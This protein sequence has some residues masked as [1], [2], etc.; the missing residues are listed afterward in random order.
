MPDLP[1]AYRRFR[2]ATRWRR[3]EGL[4]RPGLRARTFRRPQAAKRRLRDD[5]AAV[6]GRQQPIGGNFWDG[7]ATGHLLGNPAADQALGPFLNPVEQGLP[8]RACVIFRMRDYGSL[9]TD[10]WGSEINTIS[11]PMNTA[12][13][14][15]DPTLT[16]LAIGG[17]IALSAADRLEVDRQYENV[18]LSLAAFEHT[19]NRFSSRFDRGEMTTQE[20]EGQKLFSGKGKCQQCHANKGSEPLFTDFAFHNLGVP[21]NPNNPVYHP[22]TTAFDRGLGGVTGQA[23]HMGKFRTPTTRNVGLGSN[24]SYMH[25][26]ALISLEKVVD[27]YNTRDVLPV[28]SDPAVLN[29]PT[30]WGSADFGGSGCWPAAEYGAN[31]DTK[32]MGKLGL[33]KAE[34]EAVVAY[35][36]AMTDQ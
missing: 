21:K 27:F 7:R 35:M 22:N 25:N 11:F 8:D 29:D 15:A 26:G 34:V 12:S 4:G 9:Y 1:R 10:V 16:P 19:F 24:R 6:F 32:N 23:R 5:G 30:R 13:V 2:R 36:K 31:L 20:I 33:T 17:H 14:C 18:A 3:D 28:C